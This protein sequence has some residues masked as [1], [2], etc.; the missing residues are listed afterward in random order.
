M[1]D[2]KVSVLTPIYNHDVKY[3]RKCLESLQAQTL[4]ECEFILID[5]G[6]TPEAKALIEEFL[7]KDK[8]FTVIHFAENQGY[9]RAVNIGTN[10][11]KGKYI[12]FLESDDFADPEMFADL[13]D[14]SDN[15]KIDIIKSL[16]KMLNEKNQLT[17]EKNFPDSQCDKVLKKGECTGLIQKH[18]SHWSGIYNKNFLQ[19]N[20]IVFNET[21]GGHSQ[22][23]GFML[24]C[25]ACADSV[26][27]IHHAYVT[28]RLYSGVHQTKFLNDCMLD[29]LE[30]TLKKLR[31]KNL[32]KEIW[33]VIF[34]RI[35]P[36]LKSC[37]NTAD[38]SQKKRIAKELS[39]NEKYQSYKYFSQK[40]K[41]EIE[42]IITQT[43]CLHKIYDFIYANKKDGS[44]NRT[45]VC[46]ITVFC[47]KKHNNV[48]RY[49]LFGIP[50]YYKKSENGKTI[51][52]HFFTLLKSITS[53]TTIRYYFLGLPVLAKKDTEQKKYIKFLGI[54]LYYKTNI[55]YDLKKSI[56]L[57]DKKIQEIKYENSKSN[58][59]RE[60]LKSAIENLKP[61]IEASVVHPE[62]FGCYKNAFAEKDVVLVCTGP[63]AKYYT[64]LKNMIHIGVNGAIY[65]NKQLD[66]LFVQDNTIKQKGNE[67]L[68][69]DINA[70]LPGICKKFYGIIP[71]N[72]LIKV[73]PLGIERIPLSYTNGDLISQ[74]ILEGI[75]CHNWAYDLSREPMGDFSGT[76]FS[77]MQFILYGNAKRIYLVGCDCSSGYA[78]NDRKNFQP[79]TGHKN[80]WIKYV[81]PY[82][83]TYFPDLKIISINPE[84]L[85]GVFHDVYTQSYLD[86]HPEL[87]K[88]N[89]ELL[90]EK[91][92]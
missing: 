19:K 29:E 2:I 73:S 24:Q 9:G 12:G 14:K 23:F 66:F 61:I 77:A 84:G 58:L 67:R 38:A 5:N 65:L 49:N 40:E 13:F 45:K 26:Y 10:T 32:S 6:A 36:R 18:V 47:I 16:F 89:V 76:A 46:G 8:R 1:T 25:Y 50:T 20:K 52:K 44:V 51:R 87:M 11:A 75:P 68:N 60:N 72:R 22:D 17:F 28:Y 31:K 39:L 63:T 37:M 4:R 3:T 80:I 83:K 78:Y 34:F 54:P 62:T 55:L 41:K 69:L 21:P 56:C 81:Y 30:L 70:Y 33:D 82:V 42:Q 71:P 27:I 43:R 74:Y 53:S 92:K 35:A 91:G 15:G 86:E 57:L 90:N 48:V 7:H 59:Y 79:V 85:R 64:P 88:Q